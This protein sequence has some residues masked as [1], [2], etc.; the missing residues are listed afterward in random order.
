MR[1]SYKFV[2]YK[3]KANWAQIFLG[4]ALDGNYT[5][6]FHKNYSI[7]LALKLL[8]IPK[9]SSIIWLF[10]KYYKIHFTHQKTSILIALNK[11]TFR[12]STTLLMKNVSFL[13]WKRIKIAF[14]MIIWVDGFVILITKEATSFKDTNVG[15]VMLKLN[16]ANEISTINYF[17]SEYYCNRYKETRLRWAFHELI[18]K[19]IIT[20][21]FF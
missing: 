6:V 11:T 19:F 10:A 15:T 12:T 16:R 3:N 8:L 13:K 20:N 21:E 1:K 9:Y 18:T 7:L 5:D 14:S 17:T 2:H 4:R